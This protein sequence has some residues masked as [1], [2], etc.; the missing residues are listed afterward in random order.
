MAPLDR[1]PPVALP[2]PRKRPAPVPCSS[3]LPSTRAPA[4]AGPSSVPLVTLP[5]APSPPWISD[6]FSRWAESFWCP[7]IAS[8]ACDV[9]RGGLRLRPSI[10]LSSVQKFRNSPSSVGKENMLREKILKEVCLGRMA[11]PFTSPPFSAFRS[12]PLGLV[13]KDKH[14]PSSTRMRI[15]CNLSKGSPSS[16]ND[17]FWRP[18][19]ISLHVSPAMLRDQ[20]AVSG[21]GSRLW[22]ADIPDCFRN[23]VT[24]RSL[25]PFFVY[26]VSTLAHGEE[27]FVDLCNCFGWRPSEWG[28][29]LV[30]A[31]IM[32]RFRDVWGF[33]AYVDNFFLLSPPSVDHSALVRLVTSELAAMGTPLHEV[34]S[35]FRM[36]A[37]GWWFDSSPGAFGLWCTED[38]WKIYCSYLSSWGCAR[39]LSLADVRKAVGLLQYI[40][41]VWTIGKADVAALVALRTQGDAILAR[42]SRLSPSSIMLR[43]PAAAR[44]SLQF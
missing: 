41:T 16:T 32:W 28:W 14:D 10:G 24:H 29:Q 23:N 33:F 21:P 4:D 6:T 37:L 1:S 15:T 5:L 22:A 18:L 8:L 19:L 42:S 25:L 12:A 35:G 20:L 44:E 34:Q 11:G 17:G 2:F 39:S 31:V 27:F 13:P 40:S 43:L 3:G 7:K 26:V 30:L 38:R 36:K 9:V